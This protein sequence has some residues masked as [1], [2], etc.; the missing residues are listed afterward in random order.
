[1]KE[2]IRIPEKNKKISWNKAL[3]QKPHQK[4]KHWKSLSFKILRTI[5]KKNK[6]GSQ[7]NGPK[8][9]KIDGYAQSLT[10]SQS[11]LTLIL[12]S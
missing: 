6:G 11:E 10:S 8:G 9:K 5:I 12:V 2:K 7:R 3:Q 1:M 4:N